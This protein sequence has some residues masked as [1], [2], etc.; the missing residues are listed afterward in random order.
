MFLFLWIFLVSMLTQA[1]SDSVKTQIKLS[2]STGFGTPDGTLISKEIGAD[3]GQIASEDGRVELI[4]PVGALAKNTLISIQPRTN[5]S[6]NGVGKSYWFEPSGI[7]FQKPVQIK[8]RYSDDEADI[9][10]PDWM[11]LGIQDHRGIWTF[12]DYES[13][14]SVSKTLKGFIE[15]FS[16]VSNVNDVRI[17]PD[18]RII[19]VNETTHMA[20]IDIARISPDGIPY[21][22]TSYSF[23]PIAVNN[24]LLWY[25][26]GVLHGNAQTGKISGI[27]YESVRFTAKTIIGRYSAP[28][29]MSLTLLENNPVT[30]WTEIYRKTR[31]GKVLRKRLSTH[32]LVY[33]EYDVR[34]NAFVDNT[35]LGPFTQKWTDESTFKIIVGKSFGLSHI[36][37]SD[38]SN[39]VYKLE[40]EN[41]SN[42]DCQFVY[43]NS[44]TC[45]GP[46]HVVGIS[47]SGVSGGSADTYVTATVDFV[48]VPWELPKLRITCRGMSVPNMEIPPLP[49]FPHKIK[50]QLKPGT[51]T[52][53]Y[54]A[55]ADF[56]PGG[57]I[58]I[59]I[60][61]VT[62]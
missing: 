37:I 26:N 27:E 48:R 18:K 43:Q 10:P 31:K 5:L 13:F 1:Q 51:S 60:K 54:S 41:F 47:G 44:A 21:G 52:E 45:K 58:T 30:I 53:Q 46:I 16:A 7:Q 4:F 59:T 12:I 56:L 57:K 2:D 38:T 33:D 29:I 40:K 35:N 36:S 34:V 11:S 61:Q 25:A 42:N 6:P 24:T 55:A 22:D 62:E 14:D 19:R 8:V 17:I 32:I 9:C 50:F 23:A 39:K 49:A 28:R 15:H 20:L 3:G